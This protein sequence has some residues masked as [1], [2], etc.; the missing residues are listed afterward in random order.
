MITTI[1][2]FHT[3]VV[4]VP[5]AKQSKISILT[6]ILKPQKTISLPVKPRCCKMKI[7]YE[8]LHFGR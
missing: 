5:C 8:A 7:S 4:E 1:F 3:I 6:T 2:R